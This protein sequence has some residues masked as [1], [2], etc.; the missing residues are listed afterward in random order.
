MMRYWLRSSLIAVARL[1]AKPIA[2][3]ASPADANDIIALASA[4]LNNSR[5]RRRA[6]FIASVSAT[7]L[8]K[9]DS[10]VGAASERAVGPPVGSAVELMDGNVVLPLFRLT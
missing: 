7:D 10:A 4:P 6:S 8:V 9:S 2:F 1:A 5:G 3:K